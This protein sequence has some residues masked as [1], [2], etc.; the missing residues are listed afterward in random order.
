MAC[1]VGIILSDALSLEEIVD[2]SMMLKSL[3]DLYMTNYF[4]VGV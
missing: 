1:N 3:K 2:D 4:I